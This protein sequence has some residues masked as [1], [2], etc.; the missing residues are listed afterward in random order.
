MQTHCEVVQ[1]RQ[2]IAAVYILEKRICLAATTLLQTR[3]T[4]PAWGM[5]SADAACQTTMQPSNSRWQQTTVLTPA[6]LNRYPCR[7]RLAGGASAGT[8]AKAGAALKRWCAACHVLERRC[9]A[10]PSA[11]P[12]CAQPSSAPLPAWPVPWSGP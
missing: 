10:S 6:L 2:V 5:N 9:A 8:P 1:Q 7:W 11:A 3:D 12:D 4:Q